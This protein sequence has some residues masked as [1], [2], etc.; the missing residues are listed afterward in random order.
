MKIQY[1]EK[2]FRQTSLAIID[3]A[4]EIIATYL[5]MGLDLTLRQLY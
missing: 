5:E 1:I 3:K 4:N 2:R